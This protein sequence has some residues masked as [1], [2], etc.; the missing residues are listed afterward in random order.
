MN[1]PAEFKKCPDL[2]VSPPSPEEIQEQWGD[3]DS[4]VLQRCYELVKQDITRGAQYW[5]MRQSGSNDRFA[6][7]ISLQSGPGLSTDDTFFH[8]QKPLYDQFGSQ[9][10]LDRYLQAAKKRG[11]TP[12]T[13]ATYFPNLARFQGDPEAFVT[14]A[15]GRSY[16][17]KLCER[18]GWACEGDINVN[19]REPES[20]PLASENCKPL[21]EDIIRDRAAEMVKKDPGLKRLNRTE[22]R[23]KIISNHGP[24]K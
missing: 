10:H 8:G 15:Q 22:L 5:M 13:N 11:F 6:A 24:R 14:R 9:K 17:R 21:G 2:I 7:M 16:I 3:V 12:S 19:H 1:I 20:D 18:R 4:S 23:E